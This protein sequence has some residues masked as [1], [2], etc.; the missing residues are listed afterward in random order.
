MKQDLIQELIETARCEWP[1]V[2]AITSID[3]LSGGALRRRTLQNLKSLGKIPE[4]CF[5]RQG[6]RKLLIIRDPFLQW[7]KNQLG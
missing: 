3:K 1:P 2:L 7:W 6:R 5:L 4:T